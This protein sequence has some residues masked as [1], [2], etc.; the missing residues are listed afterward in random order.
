[1][2]HL[3]GATTPGLVVFQFSQRGIGF[4]VGCTDS[5]VVT[6][7]VIRSTI[8]TVAIKRTG[9]VWD[10]KTIGKRGQPFDIVVR[11]HLYA[12]GEV[13]QIKGSWAEPRGGVYISS[14]SVEWSSHEWEYPQTKP[15]K[16][17]KESKGD[18]KIKRE[19]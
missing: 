5:A 10:T 11:I 7:P 12:H 19:Y 4:V 16:K 3:T 8:F 1:M 14:G 17:K 6:R 13:K 15:K 9:L 18:K 2:S